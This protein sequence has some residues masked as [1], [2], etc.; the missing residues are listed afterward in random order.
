MPNGAVSKVETMAVGEA[1]KNVVKE[2]EHAYKSE[3]K[4]DEK[5]PSVLMNAVDIEMNFKNVTV[6]SSGKLSLSK[7][8]TE[9]STMEIRLATRFL[10]PPLQQHEDDEPPPK[11]DDQPPPDKGLR[12]GQNTKK[13]QPENSAKTNPN[14]LA[15]DVVYALYVKKDGKVKEVT[16]VS[17][18]N[19][20]LKNAATAALL[21]WEYE[22]TLFDN[23]QIPY[24][25]IARVSFIKRN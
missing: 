5:S 11:K 9:S 4:G 24:V 22:S 8:N 2:V 18:G 25:H 23:V 20:D 12:V 10:P 3:M 6:S 19:S 13:P 14:N 16:H 15:G 21:K 1:L 17:G 7:T